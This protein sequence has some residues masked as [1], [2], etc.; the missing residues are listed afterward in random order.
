MTSLPI[1]RAG[2]FF[3][4]K[5]VQQEMCDDC[6][7]PL[8]KADDTLDFKDFPYFQDTHTYVAAPITTISLSRLLHADWELPLWPAVEVR[9]LP[10]NSI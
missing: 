8:K 4:K 1:K 2:Q 3:C 5:Q 10:P 7:M 9:A 6:D